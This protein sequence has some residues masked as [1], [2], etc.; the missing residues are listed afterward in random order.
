MSQPR[1]PV[2]WILGAGQCVYW[3]ILY[4]AFSV[5]LV[6][7]R[8][9]WGTSDAAIAGAFS[10]GLAVNAM[11]VTAA[12]RWLD[13]G[14]GVV[15]LRGGALSG[16]GLLLAWSWVDSLASLYAV[17][18]GLGAC[19]AL[20][21]YETAF[22][23]I[24]RAYGDP[25]NR[26][27]ALASVTVVGGLA[28]TLF[29]PLVGAGVAHLGWRLTLRV[30]IVVWLLTTLW[31]ER[32]ALPALCASDRRTRPTSASTPSGNPGDRRLLWWTGAPF[33]AA[34]FA[35]MALTTLVVPSLVARGHSIEQAAWALAALGVMQLPGRVW[36]WRGGGR[37]VSPR[38]LLVA[39]MALQIVG[40]ALLGTSSSLAGALSGVAIF[41]IG[42]G[43]HTLA[44][45]WI[46]PLIFG[47]DA[48][49]RTNGSI[50]RAQGIARAAGPFAVAA[51]SGWIDSDAVF[52]ALSLALL[53]CC[54]LACTLSRHPSLLA[55][56]AA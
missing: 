22:A 28:S 1:W 30:L 56:S 54:P 42:A 5:L 15:L 26:L 43:L 53:A 3:G 18:I 55:H 24:T 4:Y 52:L 16:A 25:A 19:M 45:P 21:L 23:L 8:D 2:V 9:E 44:R 6:P 10:A 48:A 34:T 36:L 37:A 27:R 33:V 17:W 49:G 31:L 40:L 47:T 13:R 50:A 7:M 51:A 20:V 41:G 46:V 29:L 38:G 32:A 14:H 35:A 39:P 11:L 12:G